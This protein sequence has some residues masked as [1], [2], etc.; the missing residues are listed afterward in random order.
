M[1]FARFSPYRH[2][3]S[4]STLFFTLDGLYLNEY[5]I[6]TPFFTGTSIY[7]YKEECLSACLFAMRFHTVQPISMKLSR[8]GLA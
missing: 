6:I 5:D 2:S 4:P 1:L 7:I 8:N 3:N